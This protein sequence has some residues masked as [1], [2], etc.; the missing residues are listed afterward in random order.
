MSVLKGWVQAMPLQAEDSQQEESKTQV[1]TRAELF[2]SLP[3][4]SLWEQA[5]L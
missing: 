5:A 1:K 3:A 4:P 2:Y